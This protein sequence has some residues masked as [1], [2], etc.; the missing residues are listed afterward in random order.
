MITDVVDSLII[1]VQ[2]N[3]VGATPGTIMYAV[4]PSYGCFQYP[5]VPAGK[6]TIETSTAVV[7]L[8]AVADTEVGA[9]I[10]PVTVNR[11][12]Y[13]YVGPTTVD[14]TTEIAYTV[15]NAPRW[16]AV[17]LPVA[18]RAAGPNVAFSGWVDN[19]SGSVPAVAR[20]GL[21]GYFNY[22]IVG[23]GGGVALANGASRSAVI[24]GRYEIQI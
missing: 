9:S 8:N 4:H 16:A 22:A 3:G 21:G 23:L 14:F 1:E 20:C 17:A 10:T 13:G 7:G 24:S 6:V 12:V 2:H 18:R 11:F 5:V 15:A 19:G